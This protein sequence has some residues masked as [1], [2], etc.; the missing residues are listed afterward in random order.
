MRPLSFTRRLGPS[1]RWVPAAAL[2]TAMGLAGCSSDNKEKPQGAAP[3]DM[4]EARTAGAEMPAGQTSS[5]AVQ[6]P[7][8]TQMPAREQGQSYA[9]AYP[10]G[11]RNTSQVL[12]EQT[13]PREVRVGHEYTYQ[14]RVTNLTAAPLERVRLSSTMPEGFQMTRTGPATT[15]PSERGD[16][17][18][19]NVGDLGPH[20]SRVITVTGTP[21]R[22]GQIRQCFAVRYQPPALCT[23]INVVAPAISLNKQGPDQADVCQEFQWRYT[24]RNTGTGVAR[25]VTLRDQ[26]PE[27][28]TTTDGRRVVEANVGDIPAGQARDVVAHLKASQAGRFASA[29]VASSEGDTVNSEAV[30]TAVRQ[31]TLAVAIKGPEQ[32]YVNT[33]ITYQVTVTNT[34]DTPARD[35]AVRVTP[36]GNAQ[37]VNVT[38]PDGAQLASAGT[39]PERLGTIQPGQSKTINLTYQATQRGALQLEARATAACAP[40]AAQSVQTNVQALAALLLEAVDEHDPVRVGNN[41]VYDIV[42]TNQGNAPDSNVRVTATIPQGEEFVQATGATP[43]SATGQTITFT[44][45]T[46]LEPKQSARWKVTVKA[47]QPGAVQFRVNATSDSVKAPAEKAEPTTLY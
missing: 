45:V 30:A 27:G 13:G 15:Q 28:L 39:G 37:L 16:A 33:P 31:P 42:V 5:P 21:S 9:L 26:L 1:F 35:A 2:M 24:I 46:T 17:M 36:R 11:D 8:T 47:A 10:T 3:A 20:E 4:S 25:N 6:A 32:D 12:I 41:V 38:A 23:T 7:G 19:F 22:Q 43:A 29:A 18:V 34:G 44:P 14:I 40:E